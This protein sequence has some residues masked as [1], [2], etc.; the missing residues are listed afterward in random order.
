[1]F[2]RDLVWNPQSVPQ[3]LESTEQLIPSPPGEALRS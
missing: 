1:M 2:E 3:L